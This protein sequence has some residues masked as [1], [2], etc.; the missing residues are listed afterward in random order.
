MTTAVHHDPSTSSAR[1]DA[2]RMLKELQRTRDPDLRARLIE[3]HLPLVRALARRFAGRAEMD[4]L[5]QVGTIGLIVA[6]DRFDVARGTSLASY[7]IPTIL[8]EMRHYL[9]RHERPGWEPDPASGRPYPPDAERRSDGR[10]EH[11]FARGEQRLLL[12]QSLRA[13]GPRERLVV[14]LRFYHDLPQERIGALVGLSQ[15]HV[16]R[17]LDTSIARLRTGLLEE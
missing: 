8:G 4:D 13:L 14:F 2:L 6:I 12:E 1:G 7:A 17:L 9:R 11:S 16:G 15:V 10:S 5:V 3:S